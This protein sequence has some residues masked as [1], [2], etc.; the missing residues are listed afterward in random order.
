MS[1]FIVIEG[2][3]RVGKATQTKLLKKY[4]QNLGYKALI[5]EVPIHSN[6]TYRA[7]YWM[8]QN[9]LVKKFPKFFQ[10]LQYFNRQVFQW[11][12]L[13]DLEKEYDYI[14][15]DRWSLSTVVYGAANSVPSDFTNKLYKRLRKP[16]YTVVLLG[17]SHSHEAEDEYEKDSELQKKVR[18]LY[19]EWAIVRPNESSII[20][21]NNSREVVAKN[22]QDCLTKSSIIVE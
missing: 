2:P 21:C 19:Y 14:V 20:D 13:K 17:D 12:R 11:F 16:D 18:T 6:F 8:L 7:I 4:L 5:I 9:G 1:R 10:W 3:D 15:M 22:I